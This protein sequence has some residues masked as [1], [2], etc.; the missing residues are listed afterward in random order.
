MKGT[1]ANLFDVR[2]SHALEALLVSLVNLWNLVLILLEL[3]NQ[4]GG[5]ELAVASSGLDDLGLLFQCKVLPGEV[6]TDVFF[7]KRQNLVVGDGTWVREVVD[8]G[9][10]V[11]GQENRGGQEIVEDRVG[12]GDVYNSL[13]LCN[14]G[15]EVTGVQVVADWHSESEN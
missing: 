3:V 4:L 15:D 11:F 7:E 8:T 12:V 2:L 5:V 10:L 1:S 13:V 6:W 9:L 14:L